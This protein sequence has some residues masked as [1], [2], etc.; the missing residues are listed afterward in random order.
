[1]PVPPQWVVQNIPPTEE[2]QAQ[3]SLKEEVSE[4]LVAAMNY[5]LYKFVLEVR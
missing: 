5:W 2:E 4:M 1:M 3:N